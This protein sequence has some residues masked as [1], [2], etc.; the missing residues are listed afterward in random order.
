MKT[1]LNNTP[2][3]RKISRTIVFL[4]LPW[5]GVPEQ[6]LTFAAAP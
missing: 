4:L 3:T 5:G 2:A 1:R 6:F